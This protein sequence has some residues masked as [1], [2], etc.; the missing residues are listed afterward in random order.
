MLPPAFNVISSSGTRTITQVAVWIP[1][2]QRKILGGASVSRRLIF[3]HSVSKQ[4]GWAPRR[5]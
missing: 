4:E 3:I 2:P 5:S 1:I